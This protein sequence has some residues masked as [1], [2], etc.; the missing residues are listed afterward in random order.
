MRIGIF[1]GSFNPIHSGHV[2][3]ADW[4]VAEG[5]VDELWLMVSPHNPLKAR[6]DLMDD[7]LRLQ[8]AREAVAGHAGV[9]VSD[10]EFALPR[11]SYM[12]NTLRALSAE[13]PED[14]LVLVIGADNWAR[15]DEWSESAFI[16]E[17]Y[18]IIVYPRE[19]Y[20]APALDCAQAQGAQGVQGVQGVQALGAPLHNISSTAIRQRRTAVVILNYNGAAMLQQFLPSVLEHTPHAQVIV[21][22]NGSSDASLTVLAEQFAEVPVI[23]LAENY[24]F[25]EG[26]NRALSELTA[27]YYVLLN[28]DVAVTAGWLDPIINYMNLHGDV[29]AA[30][31]KL[32]KYFPPTDQQRPDASQSPDASQRPPR[33]EY[34]GAAGGFIDRWGYPYCRGRL[35]NT[36]EDD[37]GQ[38]DT[39]MEVHWATGACLVVR[40]ED[41]WAVGGLDGSFFAH[42][43]EIDLCWRLRNSGRRVMCLPQS[44]VYH[45]GGGT[46]PQGNPRKT[47]LNFRNNLTML[48]KNLPAEELR[49]VLRVRRWLDALACLVSLA[50]GDLA[51]ARAIRRARK[52]WKTKTAKQCNNSFCK[53]AKC[54][55]EQ[56]NMTSRFSIL[57]QYHVRRR[58]TWSA[59]PT[60][61]VTLL[62]ALTLNVNAQSNIA[63]NRCAYHSSAWDYNLTAQLLTDGIIHEGE[64]P[65]IEVRCNGELLP[66]NTREYAFD[67]NDYNRN[68]LR[69]EHSVYEILWHG[70]AVDV[71]SV[72]VNYIVAYHPE[73]VSGELPGKAW[74]YELH[75]D[76]N[77]Q[78]EREELPVRSV[79][80]CIALPGGPHTRFLLNLDLVGAEYWAISD[81]KFFK[82]GAPVY[83]DPL[84]I[85]H[86]GSV[87][88]SETGG[89]QWVEICCAGEVD[90]VK[91]HWAQDEPQHR[92]IVG[93]DRVR[94]EMWGQDEPYRI[95]EIEVLSEQRN[96]ETTTA[97]QAR[98]E[99]AFASVRNAT[100]ELCRAIRGVGAESD[101]NNEITKQRNNA[102]WRVRR[103][104]SDNWLPATV[105]ATVLTS[106][107]NA[108]AVPDQNYDDNVL[109]ASESYFNSNFEYECRFIGEAPQGEHIFLNLDGVNWKATITLNDEYVGRVEGAFKRGRFDVTSLLREGEN[110]LRVMVECPAHPGATKEKT[111]DYPGP[112]G[113]LLGLDNPTFHAS[114]GWDWIPSV[115]GRQTGIYNDIYFTREGAVTLADPFVTT[116]LDQ[117]QTIAVGA[118]SA[119][120]SLT[121]SV[122][123]HNNTGAPV[124]GTLCAWVGEISVEQEL[125]L[126][127]GEG[128]YLFDHEDYE[129][130]RRNNLRLWWPNNYGE[131]YLYDAGFALLSEQGDTI[132]TLRFKHGVRQVSYTGEQERLQ[133]Y[134]N[135][136]R[137]V[138]LGGNWGFS[139]QNLRY[140][141]REYDIAVRNHR[142]MNF[143]II[144]N[145]VGQVADEEFY[146]ACDKYGIL[147]W[148]DFWLA[149]PADG[150]DPADEEIFMEKARDLVAKIRRHPALGITCGRNE[151]YPPATLD[152]ALRHLVA[153]QHSDLTYISSSADDGVSGHGPYWALPAKDYFER[154]TGLLHTERGMPNIMTIEGQRRTFRQEHLWPQ[155]DV[156]GQHD[157]TMTGAQKGASFNALIAQRFDGLSNASDQEKATAPMSAEEF[158]RWAQLISYE[159]YRAMFESG[160]KDRM[161]LLIWMSHPC[162][163]SQTWQCY[164]YYFEPIGGYFGA[165]K[166]CE[167]LHA[168]WNASTGQVELV[169]RAV[170]NRTLTVVAESYNLAGKRLSKQTWKNVASTSDSTIALGESTGAFLRL[171]LYDGKTRIATNDY[172]AQ[173]NLANIATASVT[174]TFDGQTATLTNTGNTTAYLVR[175]NL[176]DGEGEQILPVN[177]SDNYL[178]L[179]PGEKRTINI[180]YDNNDQQHDGTS[181]KITGLNL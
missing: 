134:V 50:K 61:L 103:V 56:H 149:N 15:F 113:G 73:K 180:T 175:L 138:P 169:N 139:E 128:E 170:G 60:M 58:K 47:Y 4:V 2:A 165:K 176:V 142:D 152:S 167:P 137:I 114:V 110:V 122:K 101:T 179:L 52:E 115:R 141:A 130:L 12:A 146:D 8:L 124:K 125:T 112:N 40:A 18:E 135:N 32:L 159:G 29:A 17:H 67:G 34:A 42:Q 162:W 69:G 161:G 63:L 7:T 10:Y 99:P 66:K 109:Y 72:V 107:V 95:S 163:P 77:K 22:D 154:Q 30:Q 90:D 118:T 26:Y 117:Q 46:L 45:L 33:F 35:F 62:A 143:N 5:L 94:V 89:E 151:G 119:V 88:M 64:T 3:I 25:A 160:S 31:P 120:A 106:Y 75:S 177:Y 27:D 136:Q 79:Q 83:N 108:G 13:R 129:A 116:L 71:D 57:W 68:I 9:L 16:R 41:Y 155:N 111:Y 157:Y 158:T 173:S 104:G 38:Y 48:S 121:P 19:G 85:A 6:E 24:G 147:V 55:T 131:P 92:V 174:C 97:R 133:I 164:D 59:L 53:R 14:E 126:P 87:W 140:T 82:H 178:N 127:A 49:R 172:I 36:I 144:R 145:W 93:D 148:Q 28:S 168:Q 105:P 123:Y 81:M 80:E 153:T 86:F 132:S 96:N 181:V 84:S 1:G 11:P 43:E 51:D 20:T 39:P 166:G 54:R 102:T 156:W 78:I 91:I 98:A 76:P 37:H 44:S 21:A 100:F 65:Y 171:T 23:R 74:G 70:F 150:P